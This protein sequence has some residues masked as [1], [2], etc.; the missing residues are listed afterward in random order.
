[1]IYSEYNL[2]VILEMEKVNKYIS[3]I[4]LDTMPKG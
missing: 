2:Y 1:M 4:L 3:R